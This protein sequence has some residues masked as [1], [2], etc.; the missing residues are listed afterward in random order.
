MKGMGRTITTALLVALASVG[1]CGGEHTQTVGSETNWLGR[2][3]DD[4]DCRQGQCLCGVCTTECTTTETCEGVTTTCVAEGSAPYQSL[5]VETTTAPPTGICLE[6][7]SAGN[8]CA[9]GNHCIDGACVPDPKPPAPEDYVGRLCVQEYESV[10][11]WAGDSVTS[12]TIEDPDE[13][14]DNAGLCLTY[15][16]QGRSTCPYGGS[17]CLTPEGEPVT[18]EVTPQLVSRPPA[19]T[20]FC[21]CG[22]DGPPETG[23]FCECPSGFSCI[24]VNEPFDINYYPTHFCMP[25]EAAFDPANFD[26]TECDPELANCEDR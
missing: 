6:S 16:F 4:S 5:C 19:T 9:I 3:G 11:D 2:C 7:C 22:C 25:P 26:E 21:T 12:V 14:C 23:P 15:R 10:R 24:K 8:P 17:D 13:R 18:E 20:M 1:A